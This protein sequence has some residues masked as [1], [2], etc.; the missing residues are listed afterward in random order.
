MSGP[1]AIGELARQTGLVQGIARDPF[2]QGL[3]RYQAIGKPVLARNIG[4]DVGN[5]SET[6]QKSIAAVLTA[7]S[8]PEL[9][10]AV[11]QMHALLDAREQELTGGKAELRPTAKPTVS[12]E[13]AKAEL[14]RR[15]IEVP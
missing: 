1:T 12:P 8:K 14:R 11:R 10:D 6:E 5:L 2:L 3:Q 4:G 7:A 13:E 9:Q 15:G